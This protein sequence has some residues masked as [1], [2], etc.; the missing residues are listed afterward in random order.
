MLKQTLC[1]GVVAVSFATGVSAFPY[2]NEAGCA[3]YHGKAAGASDA[4]TLAYFDKIERHE[5]SCPV[6]SRTALGNGDVRLDV[7]CS[8]EGETWREV[9][10]V[11]VNPNADT[12]TLFSERA[13]DYKIE[14]SKCADT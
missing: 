7:E 9:Y 10:I 8:G 11:S 6:L 13:P 5:S 14:L 12:L 1:A 3:R 2:G 4:A